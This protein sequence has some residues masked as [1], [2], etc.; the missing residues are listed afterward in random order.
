MMIIAVFLLAV[1]G[2][3]AVL[4]LFAVFIVIIIVDVPPIDRRSP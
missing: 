1:N 4:S 3:A 2:A